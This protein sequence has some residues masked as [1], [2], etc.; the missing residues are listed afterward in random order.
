MRCGKQLPETPGHCPPATVAPHRAPSSCSGKRTQWWQ[1]APPLQHYGLLRGSPYWDLAPRIAGECAWFYRWESDP[2][3]PPATA[4]GVGLGRPRSHRQCPRS[5]PEQWFCSSQDPAT[6]TP[7][8]GTLQGADRPDSRPQLR[9]L[10]LELVRPG[11]EWNHSASHCGVRP[12]ALSDRKGWQQLLE[13]IQPSGSGARRAACR[14]DGPQSQ[15]HTQPGVF[16]CYVLG[17][18]RG[19]NS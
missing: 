6:S 19:I 15:G 3:P 7:D 5:R 13:A 10:A 18:G 11:E 12:Q 17:T 16:L 8:Q 1:Q 9:S 14:A 4:R 2:P